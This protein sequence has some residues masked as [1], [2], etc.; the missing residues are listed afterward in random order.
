MKQRMMGAIAIKPTKN[1]QG[2]V[3]FFSLSSGEILDRK[4]EDY[5]LLPMQAEAIKQVNRM[6]WKSRRGLEFSDRNNNV[7]LSDEENSVIWMRSTCQRKS[8]MI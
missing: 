8:I 2:G 6:G 4:R 5:V 7:T 3:N 1:L